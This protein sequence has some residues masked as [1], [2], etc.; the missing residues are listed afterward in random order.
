MSRRLL[1]PPSCSDFPC[2]VR[3]L[4]PPTILPQFTFPQHSPC[5]VPCDVQFYISTYVSDSY[6]FSW[7]YLPCPML[8][9]HP[10]LTNHGQ[11]T[12]N[13]GK[14]SYLV[15]YSRTFLPACPC[16][17]TPQFACLGRFS[18][19]VDYSRSFPF[20]R[21]PALARHIILGS[22]VVSISRSSSSPRLRRT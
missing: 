9:L 2:L 13:L 5:A 8:S 15:D 3:P 20:P 14:S 16:T 21:F 11:P 10:P 12:A 22:H 18:Y 19:L 4:L 7:F 17:W 1:P 6:V